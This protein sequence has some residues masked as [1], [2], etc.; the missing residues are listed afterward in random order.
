MVLARFGIQ[1]LLAIAPAGLPRFESIQIDPAALAFSVLAG[2]ASAVLFGVVPAVRAARPDMMTV[3]RSSGRT[4]NLG[5]GAVL[6]NTVVILEVALCFVLL[7]GS[8]LMFRTF[9]AI[10]RVN[11]GFDARNLL[12]VQLVGPAGNTPDARAAFMRKIH[13]HLA[14]LPGV[15]SVAATVPF[16]LAGGFSP[17]RWGTGEA[18]TDM[19]KFQAADLQIVTPGYFETVRTPLLEGRTFSDADNAPDRNLLIVD[20]ALAA[21]AFGRESAV[22][23][24]ILFRVRTAQAQWGEIIGVVAHQRDVSLANPGREQIYVTD[25]Y[26]FHGAAG[27][28]AL[29]TA[30]D[31]AAYAAAVRAE[32][33]KTAPDQLISEIEPAEDLV[34][35]AQGG[36]RFSLLLIGLFAAIA[37]ILAGVGLYGVLATVVRQRTAEIGVRMALGAAP[38]AILRLVVGHG[39]RLSL[40]GIAAGIL[41]AL[42]LTRLMTT[43][44]VG[45]RPTDPITYAAMIVLFLAIVAL[46][47]W[48]PAARAAG[49]APADALRDE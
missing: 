19:S 16:P 18:L 34:D 44:L 42:T 5:G 29:R 45:V 21:K 43:M 13:D 47:S 10:Q 15:R 7:I 25:G 31:P 3:L 17:V 41:A 38:G 1:Q 20:Q 46:A 28:W 12:A 8:G 30:G 48:I 24:R 9:L 14:G 23:K 22:G 39:L 2:M 6:R 35:R 27:W 4:T 11:T 40:A 33:R 32:I 26:L 49:L 36:T 37:L